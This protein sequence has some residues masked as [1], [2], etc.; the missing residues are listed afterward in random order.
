MTDP[1]F[2]DETLM[3][4]A[5]GELDSHQRKAVENAMRSD[6]GIRAR[7]DMFVETRR[8]AADALAPALREPVPDEL[9]ARVA[10][11]V[12]D[13]SGEPESD[14][15]TIVPFARPEKTAARPAAPGWAL[16][17]AASIT[18]VIGAA[19]G[20]LAGMTGGTSPGTFQTALQVEPLV[21]EALNTVASGDE[22]T[23]EG[24]GERFRA[25]AS[26]RDPDGTL[27]REF[28]VDGSNG[29]TVVAVAC[30]PG[31]TWDVQFTVVAGQTD[32]GYAPAS[33]LESLEAY[34]AAV[35][36]GEP[37]TAA[38][39]AAALTGLQ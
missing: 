1:G 29:S 36:A 5:D 33:S 34:L 20:Y 17:L 30:N 7:V 6:A 4:Y 24:T 10:A 28:E 26:Y 32:A 31:S 21:V 3:A 16:P 27:C 22:T 13:H 38:D 11:M 15:S 23:L 8:Q 12:E 39:E 18:L 37:L 14:D 25:I 35:D 2:S 19:A 9:M